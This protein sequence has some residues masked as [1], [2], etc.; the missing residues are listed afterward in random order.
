MARMKP[1]VMIENLYLIYIAQIT[2]YIKLE[3]M[4]KE[5]F[6]KGSHETIVSNEC[7]L[8]SFI[9]DHSK[10]SSIRGGKIT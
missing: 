7:K 9:A 2:G 6:L 4:K 5:I 10:I 3:I 1:N 8:T